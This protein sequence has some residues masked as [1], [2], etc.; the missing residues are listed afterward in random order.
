[1]NVSIRFN[2]IKEKSIEN[3]FLPLEVGKNFKLYFY[4]KLQLVSFLMMNSWLGFFNE[5]S[6]RTNFFPKEKTPRRTAYGIDRVKIFFHCLYAGKLQPSTYIS[7][8]FTVSSE[9]VFF[10]RPN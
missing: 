10:Q 2:Q 6:A 1:M 4:R 3:S 5:T 8:Y 7:P 9:E